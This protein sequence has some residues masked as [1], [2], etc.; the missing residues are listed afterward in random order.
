[1]NSYHRKNEVNKTKET[2]SDRE[3]MLLSFVLWLINI[4]SKNGHK[5]NTYKKKRKRT[6]KSI[7]Y[8]NLVMERKINGNSVRVRRHGFHS[9]K[10]QMN[11]ERM[12]FLLDQCMMQSTHRK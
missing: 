9:V 7:K 2:E 8:S 4:E 3:C 6:K 1:M 10:N 11:C 5:I 12:V